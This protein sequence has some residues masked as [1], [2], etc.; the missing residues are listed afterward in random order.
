MSTFKGL[1]YVKHGAVGSKSEGPL[2]YIQTR[3]QDFL[4]EYKGRQKWEPDYHLEFFCRQMVEIEGEKI[5]DS[6]I[7]VSTI[8]LSCETHI[9]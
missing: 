7:K 3:I 6:T 9:P 4:L 1:L 5:D 2:Y 8:K